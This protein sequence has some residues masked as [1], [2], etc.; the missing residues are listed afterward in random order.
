MT[1]SPQDPKLVTTTVQEYDQTQLA[2]A[3]KQQLMGMG[4]MAFMHIYMKYT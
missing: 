4:M 3:Y 1:D 2:A